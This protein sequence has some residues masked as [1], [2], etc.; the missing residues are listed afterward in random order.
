M[1]KEHHQGSDL[2]RRK[3]MKNRSQEKSGF[4]NFSVNN[5]NRKTVM[6]P[7]SNKNNKS[8]FADIFSK[9]MVNHLLF[10]IIVE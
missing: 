3:T 10:L 9:T 7:N 1:Y 2:F 4:Y 5:N 8:T 6:L